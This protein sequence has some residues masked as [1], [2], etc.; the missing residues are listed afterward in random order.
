LLQR[1]GDG[2]G[3]VLVG[4]QS[5]WE[6]IDVPGDALQCVLIDK[7]PFPPPNDPLVKA[8]AQA[9]EAR[10]GSSFDDYF[11]AEAAVSLKQGAGRLIRTEQDLGLLVVCDPRMGRMGYGKALLKALPAMTRLET[12]VQALAWLEEVATV[13]RPA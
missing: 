8:R 9:I 13:T 3:K 11:L 10:G 4:S 2:V 12:E 5:F 7:L 1:Y 6:G